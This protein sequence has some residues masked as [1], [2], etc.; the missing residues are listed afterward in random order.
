M[1]GFV[2][3]IPPL[4]RGISSC[5]GRRSARVLRVRDRCREGPDC[6]RSTLG[7]SRSS[8][9]VEIGERFGRPAPPLDAHSLVGQTPLG[10]G[11]QS[12]HWEMMTQIAASVPGSIA[13][14]VETLT[15]SGPPWA[16]AVV[17]R[18]R[19]ILLPDRWSQPPT[20]IVILSPQKTTSPIPQNRW[21]QFDQLGG[22]SHSSR[23]IL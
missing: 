12:R 13:S 18:R 7:R 2:G 16:N 22:D 11:V 10:T 21:S 3:T 19:R 17:P 1:G 8:S 14:P 15:R 23:V 9:G 20:H 4:R 6:A 5:F